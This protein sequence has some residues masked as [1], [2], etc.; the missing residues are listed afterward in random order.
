MMLTPYI[1]ES[2]ADLEK[3]R[4]R[5]QKER[6]E[7]L[8]YFGRKDLNYVRSVNY[9]KKHGILEDMRKVIDEKENE[10]NDMKQAVNVLKYPVHED[11]GIELPDGFDDG[12]SQQGQSASGS[13]GT[14]QSRPRRPQGQ[15][16]ERRQRTQQR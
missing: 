7:F 11:E 1:I 2:S 14:T 6:E 15:R 10:L 16:G 5:K 9:D 13:Q 3:I 12:Y 4:I 8:E